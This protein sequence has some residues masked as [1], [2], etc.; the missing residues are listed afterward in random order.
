[1][2][3]TFTLPKTAIASKLLSRLRNITPVVKST[4]TDNVKA[5]QDNIIRE[6]GDP[7]TKQAWQVLSGRYVEYKRSIGA[8]LT[9]LR[10]TDAMRKGIQ[11]IESDGRSYRISVRGEAQKYFAFANEKRKFLGLPQEVRERAKIRLSKY[12]K[13]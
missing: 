10:R 7:D 11:V 8:F 13:K 5:L 9:I 3:L 2:K 4:G 1:M 6:G 12:L